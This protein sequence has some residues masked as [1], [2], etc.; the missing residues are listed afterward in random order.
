MRGLLSIQYIRLPEK[1]QLQRIHLFFVV[2]YDKDTVNNAMVNL[3]S[4]DGVNAKVFGCNF[5]LILI[6]NLMFYL[7][8]RHSFGCGTFALAGPPSATEKSFCF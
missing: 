6:R 8:D 3:P 2:L 7:R 4:A 5:F 1:R